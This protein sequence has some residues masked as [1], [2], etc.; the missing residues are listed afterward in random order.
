MFRITVFSVFLGGLAS[1]SVSIESPL[2]LLAQTSRPSNIHLDAFEKLKG[3]KTKE[4]YGRL[5]KI[6]FELGYTYSVRIQAFKYL[7]EFD[8]ENLLVTIRQR[9]PRE[10]NIKWLKWQCEWIAAE[11]DKDERI[12]EAL[13]SS[14]AR[15]SKEIEDLDRPERKALRS[16]FP[17]KNAIDVVFKVFLFSRAEWQ[18]PLRLR[19]WE[20]LVRLGKSEKLS[21]LILSLDLE[22]G[23]DSLLEQLFTGVDAF[24]IIPSNREEMLW[25]MELSSKSHQR[26]IKESVDAFKRVPMKKQSNFYMRD[27]AMI[28]ALAMSNSDVFDYS[29]EALCDFIKKGRGE[30]PYY[31]NRSGFYKAIPRSAGREKFRHIKDRL[32][33][34]DLASLYY[35]QKIVFTSAP[36]CQHLFDYMDRDNADLTTEYGG[37]ISLDQK[38]RPEILE[39]RPRIR[40][41]DNKFNASQKMFTAGYTGLFHFHF[42]AAKMWNEAYAGPSDEDLEYATANGVRALVFTPINRD[43]VNVDYYQPNGMTVDLGQIERP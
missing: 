16:I 20:L 14:W 34:T 35:L 15:P 38:A 8:R 27:I 32:S 41:G 40:Q 1:C 29:R 33:W 30:Q 39:F 12:V 24:K 31:A 2:E 10:K 9:L 42:H 6:I 28:R 25:M 4:F 36:F 19:A 21:K 43:T 5:H 26:Y 22:K 11:K 18:I 3:N 37:I 23:S 7:A 17:N 13:V